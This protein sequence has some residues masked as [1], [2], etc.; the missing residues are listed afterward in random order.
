[1]AKKRISFV[2]ALQTGQFNTAL[3]M[4]QKKLGRVSRQMKKIG[5]T[6]TNN[7]TLPFV[8]I[9]AA[10]A[11][12]A[13][14][15][16]D[17]MTKIQTL[18]G[19]SADEVSK[20]RK[21]VVALSGKT[22]QA[23]AEL[24]EGLFFLTSAGLEGANA[25]ETLEQVSKGVA[26]G[27]GEQAD[28]AKVAAAAQNAYGE[29]TMS[30]SKALDIF[31]GMVQTGMFEASELA[32]VLGTQL[33]LAANLGISF[34]EL[35]AMISTYTKTTGDAN[36][37][38]TGLSGIMM[39]FAKI[40]PKQEEA[41]ASVGMTVEGL[42]NSLGTQGLQATL[43]EMQSAF[44]N[45][46]VDLSEF[47]SKSQALK[48]VLGVLGNQTETYKDVLDKLEQSTGFVN[49]GF[50]TVSKGAG[51]RLQ[52]SFNNLKIAGQQIGEAL[53]PVIVK[54]ANFVA[55]AAKSFTQLDTSTKGIIVGVGLLVASIGPMLTLLGTIGS[56]LVALTG[57]IGI[58]VGAILAIGAAFIYIRENYE[59][60]KERLSSWTWF[61]NA[62][63]DVLGFLIEFNPFSVIIKGYNKLLK[64]LGK[65]QIIN[66]FEA[67]EESLDG[68]K[69]DTV[70]YENELGSFGDALKNTANEA[71]G[72]ILN[73][74]G[75]GQFIPQAEE[76]T[77]AVNEVTDAIEEVVQKS[78][79]ATPKLKTFFGK[80]A[81]DFQNMVEK[82]ADKAEQFAAITGAMNTVFQA[83]TDRKSE[84]LQRQTDEELAQ[85]ESQHEINRQNIENSTM[86][87]EEKNAAL[88]QL[89]IDHN[90]A[91]KQIQDDAS[92]QQNKLARKQAKIQK[93]ADIFSIV[94]ST[95]RSIASA[96]AASPLTGGMPWAGINAGI[97][98]AQIAAVLAQPLP[99]LAKGGLAYGPTAAMVGDNFG[100]STDPEV[101]APLSKLQSIMGQNSVT[102]YGMIKGEDI[103]LSS[104][105]TNKRLSRIT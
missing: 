28:L 102:V 53:L 64:F 19:V 43:I 44:K 47:F 76:T 89:E 7:V 46:N 34:E 14:E 6:M 10:G 69:D 54:L 39:S 5:S 96:V 104:E 13:V 68:L 27:L 22:A 87:E 84:L 91:M 1:M 78:E 88:E 62:L 42:R 58:A 8:A 36:A 75:G 57:P 103:V 60:I 66:P 51:F 74:M 26:I 63:L 83:F 98:A 70:E 95:A 30:A 31:G 100:A 17:N 86:S 12:M 2:L 90:D 40:T 93:A 71:K 37:A 3:T 15:F 16:D 20:L 21:E 45:N 24:A 85:L 67:M 9:G 73:M 49:D 97:G 23:P 59:A 11:K 18:V 80:T 99:A 79:E 72:A 41:L 48:G 105:R 29:D 61:K 33:G 101:I 38:T 94:A 52:Q 25:M 55:S 4:A 81:D 35:G 92:K 32:G 56:A 82:I 50:D 77:E 65:E